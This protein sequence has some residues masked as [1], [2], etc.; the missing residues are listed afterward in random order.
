M[1]R[2]E[3]VN[4]LC[5]QQQPLVDYSCLNGPTH[6]CIKVALIK[7]SELFLK[8]QEIGREI[9]KMS[10]GGSWTIEEGMDMTKI[11]DTYS[12]FKIKNVPVPGPNS[13]S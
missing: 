3:G 1:L 12:I 5:R 13:Q 2:E 8:R 7:H 11:H 6:M 10:G 9:G 4:F